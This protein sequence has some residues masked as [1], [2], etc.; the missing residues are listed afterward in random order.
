LARLTRI[1][2]RD[3]RRHVTGQDRGEKDPGEKDPRR[4]I[5]GAGIFCNW[6]VAAS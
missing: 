1:C 4:E 6:P 3:K 5:D 2:G